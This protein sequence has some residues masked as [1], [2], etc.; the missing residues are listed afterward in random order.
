MAATE[1]FNGQS[2]FT[3]YYCEL[4]VLSNIVGGVPKDKD[5]IKGWLASRLDLGDAQLAE[6]TA[7]TYQEMQ[8]ARLAAREEEL[9]RQLALGLITNLNEGGQLPGLVD[10]TEVDPSNPAGFSAEPPREE[11]LETV[12]RGFEGG[13]GFKARNRGDGVEELVYEGRCM[14]AALK[15][16]ANIA[17]PGIDFPSK[18][19]IAPK[20]RKGL[21]STLAE[22]I[23]VPEEFISLGVTQATE[24]E[25]RIK[26]VSTPRGPR[27][28]INVVD[29]VFRPLLRF[30]VD[31]ADDFL[32]D[33]EWGRVWSLIEANGI[34][35][36]RARSDGKC[37]LVKWEAVP[38]SH[39]LTFPDPRYLVQA[40]TQPQALAQQQYPP[41]PQPQPQPHPQPQP[42]YQR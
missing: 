28:A 41:P 34:G 3:R 7:K 15:E 22:R 20:Y 19:N 14:K 30:H 25:Q 21:K 5:T 4:Q 31:V 9:E 32:G 24:T 6:L 12:A 18:T 2:P 27:S 11:V 29:L 1:I 37:E 8:A 38:I 17:Y 39:P 36:D 23:F 40:T 33:V 16:A 35:A 10:T 13:N 26:H 42:Q